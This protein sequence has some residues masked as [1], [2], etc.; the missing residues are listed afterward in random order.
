MVYLWAPNNPGDD[1][2]GLNNFKKAYPWW[3]NYWNFSDR[4]DYN[5]SDHWR[6]FA[7]FS[8]FETRLDNPNW[9]GTIAVPSDN[10]GI[11]DALNAAADVL[12]RPN[13]RTTV[14]FRWPSGMRG[15]QAIY[16]P[17]FT[18]NLSKRYTNR[19]SRSS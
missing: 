14:D 18:N 7:R 11:M 4:V 12:W 15:R 9:G 17:L 10:G 16:P 8:K 1:L 6:V 19:N 13:P 3:E 2:S 5:L